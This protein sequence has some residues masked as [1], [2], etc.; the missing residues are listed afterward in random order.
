MYIYKIKQ[1][2]L[3]A[4]GI[5]PSKMYYILLFYLEYIGYNVTFT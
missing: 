4:F 2:A 1:K 5:N 3:A